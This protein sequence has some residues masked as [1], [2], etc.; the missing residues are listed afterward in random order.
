[1]V[2][3]NDLA[4]TNQWL[5]QAVILQSEGRLSEAADIC[6]TILRLEPMQPDALNLLGLAEMGLGDYLL[7]KE[8]IQKAVSICPNCST[9]W[10]NLGVVYRFAGQLDNAIEAYQRSLELDPGN[11]DAHFNLGKS[12]KLKGRFAEAETYFLRSREINPMR[13]SPWL[14]LMNLYVEELKLE[15]AIQLGALALTYFPN[16]CDIR[17]GVGAVY[18]RLNRLDEA[19][20]HYRIATALSPSNL[21]AL[22]RLAST[23]ALHCEIGE[24]RTLLDQA[25]RIDR[26]S[27][28]VLN[29]LGVLH[30][31]IGDTATASQVFGQAVEKHPDNATA[32]ANLGK[33]LKKQG[34]PSLALSRIQRAR[35]LEPSNIETMIIEAGVLTSLGRL[36]E[37]DSSFRQAIELR[38]GYREAHDSLLMCMQYRPESTSE[39]ILKEHILWNELYAKPLTSPKEFQKL[40]RQNRPL[41]LGFVSADLGAHPVGFFT[42]NLFEHLDRAQFQT[43]VYSDRVGR[44]WLAAEIEKNVDHWFDSVSSS[45]A[46]LAD[47]IQSDEI[48]ILFDLA[49]HTAHNRLLVFARRVASIQISWAGYVG[50]TGL[51]EM[52]F[53]LGDSSH[54]PVGFEENYTERIL[55]MP[56]GYVSYYPPAATPDVVE[57]PA[58]SNGFFTFGAMC[59]PAKVNDRVLTTWAK[60]LSSIPRSRLLLSY[61]GWTDVSNQD[62]VRNIFRGFGCDQQVDF[63]H[64]PTSTELL[65]LY[66]QVDVALDTFPYSGGLTTIEALWMG[67]PTI[68]YPGDRFSS[69]HSMS[70]LCNVGLDDWV[71]SSLEEYVSRAQRTAREHDSLA[72]TRETLRNRMRQSPLCDGKR[73][74]TNFGSLMHSVWRKNEMREARN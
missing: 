39:Q 23:L 42:A 73:F 70:H 59:N 37:A 32:F 50:T 19:I 69:R 20:Q 38:R 9:F 51:T 44:D 66:N 27:I 14:S 71:V 57:L 62:R 55:R 12:L 6:K 74:A 16:H 26:D 46:S 7:S 72:R 47:K 8:L 56:D 21:D 65:R 3:V 13:P 4:T 35:E 31:S 34:W 63:F 40:R 68:T 43:F 64:T 49:G 60:I 2:S 29:C 15:K 48:D 11:A 5:H 10:L 22:C 41:R 30:T 67:V 18:K 25:I 53:V 24:A 33:A 17:L 1:M 54:I 61:C 58:Q 45:D 28:H 36:E 52:D